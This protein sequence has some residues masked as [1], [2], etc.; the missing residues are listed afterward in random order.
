MVQNILNNLHYAAH[1]LRAIKFPAPIYIIGDIQLRYIS[2][3]RTTV[4]W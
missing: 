1:E 3:D 4:L 2:G